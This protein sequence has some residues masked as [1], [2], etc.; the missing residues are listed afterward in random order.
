MVGKAVHGESRG[1]EAVQEGSEDMRAFHGRATAKKGGGLTLD[2]W[3]ISRGKTGMP[4]TAERISPGLPRQAG[5]S[6]GGDMSA[7]DRIEFHVFGVPATK[8]SARAFAFR[9]RN[10]KLG[11]SVTNDNPRGKPWQALV[12]AAALDAMGSAPPFTGGVCLTLEFY[13][14]RPN[15]HYGTGKN[16]DVLKRGAPP[17]PMG[18]PDLD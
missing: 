6:V 12:Q 2:S 9:R 17:D 4:L 11:V 14:E 3:D 16:R 7:P 13:M 18:K 1:C 15:G 10:G 5:E 8:G